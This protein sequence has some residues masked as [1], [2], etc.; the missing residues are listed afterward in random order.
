MILNR[1]QKGSI[2]IPQGDSGGP[3][4]IHRFKCLYTVIGITSY[5][6]DCGIP[7]SAGMYTR[8]SYYVPWIESIV[9]PVEFEQQKKLDD[10][11]LDKWL[12]KPKNLSQEIKPVM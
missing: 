10:E 9:W 4:Q 7:G 11:W 12:Q 5:G 6:K 8:V 1:F 3:L 2:G